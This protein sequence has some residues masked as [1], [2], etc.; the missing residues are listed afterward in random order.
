MVTHADAG[1]VGGLELTSPG[2][3][4][5]LVLEIKKWN[6]MKEHREEKELLVII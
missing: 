5:L 4:S 1:F 6:Q 2:M 3:N